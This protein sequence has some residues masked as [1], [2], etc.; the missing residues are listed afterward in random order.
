MTG[1]A[2]DPSYEDAEAG[3]LPK[4]KVQLTV[5]SAALSLNKDGSC[6]SFLIWFMLYA[7]HLSWILFFVFV[8]VCSLNHPTLRARLI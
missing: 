8:P 1:H 7:F 2:C 6:F 5:G 4:V 3:G